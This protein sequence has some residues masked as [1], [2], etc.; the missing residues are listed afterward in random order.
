MKK[1]KSK[2]LEFFKIIKSA[3]K[4]ANTITAISTILIVIKILILDAIPAASPE[5]QRLGDL[6][7]SLLASIISSY[8]FYFFVIHAKEENEKIMFKDFFE[9]RIGFLVSYAEI[10]LRAISNGA[11]ED[12]KLSTLTKQNLKS[13]LQK[14]NGSSDAPI[15]NGNQNLNWYFYFDHYISESKKQISIVLEKMKYLDTTTISLLT[16][17]EDC[18][19]F[20]IFPSVKQFGLHHPD[21]ST[22]TGSLFDYFEKCRNLKNNHFSESQKIN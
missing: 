1:F 17:I 3:D 15:Q 14:I 10:Q 7:S 13:A 11:G 20:T 12:L 22:Q 21:L 6:T 8:I 2:M 9:K 5:I 18:G 16:K 4:I 19:H